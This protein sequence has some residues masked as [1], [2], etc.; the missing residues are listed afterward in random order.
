MVV[1]GYWGLCLFYDHCL[2]PSQHGRNQHGRN[3]PVACH[4]EVG[5][6]SGGGVAD[7]PQ[8]AMDVV[9]T[10]SGSTIVML[11]GGDGPGSSGGSYSGE[12]GWSSEM[13]SSV[14]LAAGL[15]PEGSYK[16]RLVVVPRVHFSSQ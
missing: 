3:D 12:G 13:S 15:Q 4:P 5:A 11:A 9:P 16:N 6:S 10:G 8:A 2:Q 14:W 7:P 1:G